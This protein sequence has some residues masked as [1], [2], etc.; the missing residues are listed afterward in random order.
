M[1]KGKRTTLWSWFSS[2]P[3]CGCREWNSGHQACLAGWP[4]S[5]SPPWISLLSLRFSLLSRTA[6]MCHAWFVW[7]GDWLHVV[8]WMLHYTNYYIPIPIY[9]F[10]L[11]AI[12]NRACLRAM[13]EVERLF[14]AFYRG[15]SELTDNSECVYIHM[16]GFGSRVACVAL[17]GLDPVDLSYPVSSASQVVET[18]SLCHTVHLDTYFKFWSDFKSVRTLL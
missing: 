4:V 11:A 6:G 7:T 16:H 18:S 12:L 15:S 9:S 5:P 3:L 1:C 14:G 13:A 10:V 17:A 2:S 8:S